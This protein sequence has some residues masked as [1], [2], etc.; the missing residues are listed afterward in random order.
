MTK[1]RKPPAGKGRKPDKL[2]RDA[3]ILALMREAEDG[4]GEA[5]KRL[6]MIAGKLVEKAMAGDVQAIKE[7]CDR[8]DGR[9]TQPP[10]DEEAPQSGV[11]RVERII[12]RPEAK[13]S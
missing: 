2:M 3:L 8:V 11:L 9:P 13:D 1:P 7:I 4:T 10:G 5:V 6:H 12:V